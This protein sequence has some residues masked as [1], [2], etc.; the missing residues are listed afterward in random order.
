[1]ICSLR[2]V[3]SRIG[4]LLGGIILGVK[5]KKTSTFCDLISRFSG[6]TIESNMTEVIW[7]EKPEDFLDVLLYYNFHILLLF[8]RLY[9]ALR[10]NKI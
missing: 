9:F 10:S 8:G 6:F 7:T 3:S 1:M 2:G 5:N 4:L